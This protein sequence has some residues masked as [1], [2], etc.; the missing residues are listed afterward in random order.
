M[1]R[2]AVAP[3][4][5]TMDTDSPRFDNRLLQTLPGDPESGPRRREVLGAA[6]SPVMPTP[7]TAPTLLAWAPD[8]AAMLGFDTAEVESVS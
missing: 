6:W 8:V 3:I 1:R 5:S 7:V 4:F 2:A